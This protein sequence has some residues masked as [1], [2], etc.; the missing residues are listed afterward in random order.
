MRS[1]MPLHKIYDCNIKP[2][3]TGPLLQLER[4]TQLAVS[5][6]WSE[7]MR[8][9]QVCGRDLV[10]QVPHLTSPPPPL[11]PRLPVGIADCSF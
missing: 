5:T 7:S 3:K 11:G 1:S 9:V 6:G 2:S 10:H 8:E 4:V